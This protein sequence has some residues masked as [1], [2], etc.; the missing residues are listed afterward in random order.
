MLSW[1]VGSVKITC[2]VEIV[3]PFPDGTL[4]PEATPEASTLTGWWDQMALRRS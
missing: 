1:Q 4:L 2:V 3:I